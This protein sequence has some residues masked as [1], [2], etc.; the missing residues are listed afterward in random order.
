MPEVSVVI[1]AY[2]AEATLAETLGSVLAQTF[3]DFEVI[4]VDDG[5][6]DGTPA[7]AAATGDGR[8]RVVS[9]ENGGVARARNRGIHEAA[10][11]FVAFLDA[12]DLW[13]P[14]KLERQLTRLAAD[15]RAGMCVTAATRINSASTELEPL[16]VSKADAEDCCESLLLHSMVAGCVSS[17]LVRKGVINAAGGFNPAFSQCADWDLWLRLSRATRF[18]IVDESLVLYRVHV[19]NMSTN[20]ALLESDT[21]AVLDAFFAGPISAPYLPLRKLVYSNHWLICSGSYLHRRQIKDAVRCLLRGLRM[22]PGNIS[23]AASLPLRWARRATNQLGG[24]R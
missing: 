21:F 12:D 18:A 7:V 17:G 20:I 10:G 13:R 9:V 22:H 23:R 16:P 3:A 2:N 4:V 14:S 15:P 5:S 8:V 11:E 6:S 19:N 1:P 24:H